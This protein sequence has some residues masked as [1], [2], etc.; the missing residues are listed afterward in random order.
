[1]TLPAPTPSS[2]DITVP[3]DDGADASS[4]D[5]V[6]ACR[7]RDV[8]AAAAADVKGFADLGYAA[9]RNA[10]RWAI[11]GPTLAR[12][13][14]DAVSVSGRRSDGSTGAAAMRVIDY[15]AD[16]GFF[17]IMAARSAIQGRFDAAKTA[18]E[19]LAVERGGVGGSLWKKKGAVNVHDRARAAAVKAGL[20]S[21]T[22]SDSR[23]SAPQP[24]ASLPAFSICPITVTAKTFEGLAGHSAASSVCPATVQFVLSMLH[25]VDGVDGFAGFGTAVCALARNARATF[26]ELPHPRAKGTFGEKRYRAWYEGRAENTTAALVRAIESACPA[27]PLRVEHLGG[28]PWGPAN[29]RMSRDIQV[30]WNDNAPSTVDAAATDASCV[31]LLQ[32]QR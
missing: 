10:Q 18:V 12:I 17:G 16:Q 31:T 6:G 23:R 7:P 28:T 24:N 29:L 2:R 9:G 30:V 5:S 22:N 32:C 25:W 19:V 26:F 11:L 15:G 14:C 21:S 3:A 13:V 4:S 1:V 20:I 27:V 8:A